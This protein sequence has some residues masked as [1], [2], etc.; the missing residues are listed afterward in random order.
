MA[1]WRA[2]AQAYKPNQIIAGD[3]PG[4]ISNYAYFNASGVI[5]ACATTASTASCGQKPLLVLTGDMGVVASKLSFLASDYRVVGIDRKRGTVQDLAFMG[6]WIGLMKNASA[7]IHLA[8]IFGDDLED[9]Q[10]NNFTATGNVIRACKIHS[11]PKIIYSSSVQAEPAKY[12][13]KDTHGP[14]PS[15]WYGAGK[16]FTEDL[17]SVYAKTSGCATTAIRLGAVPHPGATQHDPSYPDNITMSDD[18]VAK[19]FRA[20]LTNALGFTLVEPTLEWA[21]P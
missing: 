9:I 19:V 6:P 10:Q 17:L 3:S 8:G 13:R 14:R 4:V 21:K 12:G 18:Q 20:A 7:V 5:V 1:A 16:R 11:I 2:S 15:D